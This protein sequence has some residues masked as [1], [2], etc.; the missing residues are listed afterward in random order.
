[1][2]KGLSS[3]RIEERDKT[4]AALKA[5][6]TGVVPLLEEG[7]RG[8]DGEVRARCSDLI[9]QLTAP[10]I[11]AVFRS[12]AVLQQ[13]L[14]GA[15]AELLKRLREEEQISFKVHDIVLSGAMTLMCRPRKIPC[16][17]GEALHKARVT[18]DVQNVSAWTLISVAAHAHG[19]DLLIRNGFVVIDTK[20]EIERQIG[21]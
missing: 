9:R 10:P 4:S 7:A 12:P 17:L 11:P 8:A 5:L 13:K 2:V 1:L 21:Q 20:D 18:L 15:D 14:A 16:R 3:D 19:F 6:G